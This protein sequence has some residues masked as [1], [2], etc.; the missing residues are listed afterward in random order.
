MA[1]SDEGREYSRPSSRVQRVRAASEPA[2]PC[3]AKLGVNLQTVHARAFV[4][5][6]SSSPPHAAHRVVSPGPRRPRRRART[7]DVEVAGMDGPLAREELVEL[8]R[9][10]VGT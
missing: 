4:C 5:G 1:E 2:T 7:R 8:V 6:A 10:R 9:G 3:H